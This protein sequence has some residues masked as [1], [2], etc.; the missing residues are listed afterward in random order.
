MVAH[1][2][3]EVGVTDHDLG[4]RFDRFRDVL[5][6]DTTDCTLSPVSFDSAWKV[7]FIS[8]VI[9]DLENRKNLII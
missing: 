1:L 3:V 2:S 6:A 8:V 4:G 9:S 7:F 5:I